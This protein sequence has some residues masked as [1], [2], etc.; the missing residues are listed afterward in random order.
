MPLAFN[1]PNLLRKPRPYDLT[2]PTT[3]HTPCCVARKQLQH[4]ASIQT[5]PCRYGLC[6]SR[7][8]ET[9]LQT[10]SHAVCI[11]S[12]QQDKLPHAYH[13]LKKVCMDSH[14]DNVLYCTALLIHMQY[15]MAL[16]LIFSNLLG[17]SVIS[18]K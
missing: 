8:V 15:F 6:S 3:A 7:S 10:L 12:S 9:L 16:I 4:T 18:V 2:S 14:I 13:R 17:Y 5:P 1:K 11:L